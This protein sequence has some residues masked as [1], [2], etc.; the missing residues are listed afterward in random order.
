M[1]ACIRCDLFRYLWLAIERGGRMQPCALVVVC[2]CLQGDAKFAAL[3]QQEL[4]VVRDSRRTRIEVQ[5]VIQVELTH[6]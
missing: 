6:L 2:K 5:T 1:P 3:A 4:V